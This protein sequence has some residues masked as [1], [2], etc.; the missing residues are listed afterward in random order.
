[1]GIVNNVHL[2]TMGVKEF[3]MAAVYLVIIQNS[4]LIRDER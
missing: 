4:R 2:T 3:S 1:M